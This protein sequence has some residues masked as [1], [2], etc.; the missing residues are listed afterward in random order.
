MRLK[1][2]K[3]DPMGH[4]KYIHLRVHSSYSLSEGAIKPQEM[5]ALCVKNQMPAVAITDTGNLFGSLEFSKAC[6]SQG[7]QPIIGCLLRIDTNKKEASL[8][9]QQ[10]I[11]DNIVLYAKSQTGYT[12]LLELVSRSFL[13]DTHGLLPHISLNLLEEYQEGLIALSGGMQGIAGRHILAN[14]KKEAVSALQRFKSIFGDRFYIE[15]Q[16]HGMAQQQAWEAG[17]TELAYEQDIPLVATN[18]VFFPVRE[19]YQAHD[20]LNCIAAGRYLAEENRPKLTPEHYFKSSGE[21]EKLFADLPEAIENT[22][23][24]AQRCAVMSSEHKPI[25]PSFTTGEGRNEAE[26]LRKQ[27]H[28]GLKLRLKKNV[29]QEGMTA[30][31]QEEIQKTYFERLEFELNVIIN[32]QFPGYFLIVSDF[33]KWSK[34]HGIPVGPGRGSGAGSVV[35]WSLEIT[36]LDPIRFGLLFERFLNP[37]RVSMPDFDV[38]FCQDRRGEVI[39]YV[40]E[41]YGHDRVAQ[42]ITFGK[43][44]ARA[45]IRDVGRVLQMPYG[46]VDKISKLVPNNPANPVT[47]SEA[48]KIEP[49]LRKLKQDDQEVARL[50]DIALK[51]EGLNRHASVHAAGVVIGDRPLQEL[52]ALYRD[53]RSDMPVVQYS[54]KY[55]EAAGLVKF[56]FLGLK[57]LT[58]I[59]RAI[60]FINARKNAEEKVDISTIPLDDP[61]TFELLSRGDSVGVFQLESA[62]MRDTLRKLK[63]DTLEE[64]IALIS[65]Y[66]PGPMDNIPTYIDCKQGRQEPDYLHP[67]LEG[68]LKETYGVIIYQEQVMQI[69]QVLSGYTLGGADLLRRAMGKKIKEEMDKQRELFVGGAVKNG[70]DEKQAD[71]IFDLVAKFAGYGFNKSH[72]AAYALISYQTAWLKA[73]YPVE[74]MAASMN[75]EINDTDK[76]NL[77]RQEAVRCNIEVLPPD[78]NKSSAWFSVETVDGGLAVRYGLAGLK[79]VGLAAMQEMEKVREPS[80]A[81][82]DV[83]DFANRADNKV[84]NK[85]QL[86][87]LIKA[88]AF[89]QLHSNRRQLFESVELLTRY[90]SSAAKER[91]SSQASLFGMVEEEEV[92]PLPS[93]PDVPDW[94]QKDRLNYELESLGFY[95]S[96]HPLD[97]Y[98]AVLEKARIYASGTLMQSLPDGTSNISLAGVLIS[99]RIRVSPRGRFAYVQLSDASGSYEVAVFDEE[100]LNQN[101]GVLE[102]GNAL[103]LAVEARKDEGGVRLIA[104][105]ISLLEDMVSN[106]K[107]TINVQLAGTDAL[108]PIKELLNSLELGRS[109]ITLCLP[110]ADAEIHFALP[111]RYKFSTDTIESLRAV[112]GVKEVEAVS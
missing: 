2:P 43:L 47:L 90:S 9:V 68:I 85:R 28:D 21:M 52:V 34:R 74:F 64:I 82:K 42:I 5:A 55:A 25:L 75:L 98:Q 106:Q 20:V 1:Q 30:E 59:S 37:E 80:G 110:S 78:I 97:E 104:T 8:Q 105:G 57:T 14:Q 44:Q 24:I 31:E 77:F 76:I 50:L 112:S 99:K 16:R 102:E 100:L 84:V 56:D 93:L 39:R 38:D 65:L 63:P 107:F 53:A 45:A 86:E 19:M 35:A 40:Q 92:I 103:L 62:G 87:S 13:E 111:G 12:N 49:Q 83:F 41:K 27:A 61:A 46:Q 70:V 7:V 36:D 23:V 58:V 79:G 101:T 108:R 96:A 10:P 29:F 72:A 6:M 48:I 18:D 33:I 91:H 69:A 67:K 51:L 60:D 3:N 17:L 15:L 4:A 22:L 88:G 54:M 26:E 66:R 89:D 11:L 32:M 109:A 71:G 73:N 81:F 95:L 94:S